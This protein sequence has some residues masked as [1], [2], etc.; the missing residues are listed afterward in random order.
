MGEASS[1]G[2]PVEITGNQAIDLF[3]V[4]GPYIKLVVDYSDSEKETISGLYVATNFPDLAQIPEDITAEGLVEMLENPEWQA[5][6]K[7]SAKLRSPNRDIDVFI[8]E[9]DYGTEYRTFIV[10]NEAPNEQDASS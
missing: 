3:L 2:N 9:P 10:R 4:D 7:H 8:H 6:W 5:K 1:D